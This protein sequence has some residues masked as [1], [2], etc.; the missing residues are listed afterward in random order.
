MRVII[1]AQRTILLDVQGSN[2]WS[3]QQVQVRAYE[4]IRVYN[5]VSVLIHY[6]SHSTATQSHGVLLEISSMHRTVVMAYVLYHIISDDY[7]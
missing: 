5:L 4:N 7:S 3:G 2:V 1:K 6:P